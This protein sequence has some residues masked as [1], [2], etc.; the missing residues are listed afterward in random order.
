MVKSKNKYNWEHGALLEDH[1][2]QKLK[3]LR[4]YFYQ[5]LDTRCKFPQQEVF[6]LSIVDGFAGGGKYKC[7]SPGSPIIFIEELLKF[8]NQIN[9][10][11]KTNKF[12]PLHIECLLLLNDLDPAAINLLKENIYP[13]IQEIKANRYLIIHFQYTE[14]KFKSN[15]PTIREKIEKS[16]CRNNVLFNLDQFGQTD[17]DINTIR[18]ILRSFPRT[19]I[20]YT[21]AIQ[22]FLT[23]ANE[24]SIIPYKQILNE[25]N[26][27][28]NDALDPGYLITRQE[29]LGV[30]ERMVFDAFSSCS[31]FVSPFSINNPTGWKY[32]LL[33]FSNVYRAREVYNNILHQ[34]S[35]S[36]AHFGRSGLNMLSYNS[37]EQDSFLY[38]FDMAASEQTKQ[39]L[40]IDIPQF[41]SNY[42]DTIPM[43]DF[44]N[45]IYNQTPASSNIIKQ[46]LI[47]IP[48][49]KIIKE[50]GGVRR[51]AKS[52]NTKSDTIILKDQKSFFSFFIK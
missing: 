5:Y 25:N 19:E 51:S 8:S 16:N 23:Y 45:D 37:T 6:R 50:D 48:D 39:Q 36:Q 43:L 11:R 20:F 47:D 28:T 22:A 40:L 44:F 26:I 21:F 17:A 41:V 4:N 3:I 27:S 33:H 46:S 49:I 7:G 2:K 34:V 35:S 32:W 12:K 29:E 9:I 52:I 15:Y 18:T 14:G 13:Y 10:F 1:S 38:K 31:T 24:K 30:Y 42:G